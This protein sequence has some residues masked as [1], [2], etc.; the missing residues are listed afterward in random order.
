[1][2][3]TLEHLI[4]GQPLGLTDEEC[5]LKLPDGRSVT[6][7]YI[8]NKLDTVATKLR[9][10][11]Y[12]I[13]VR[14]TG[15]HYFGSTNDLYQRLVNHRGS[16]TRGVHKNRFFRAIDLINPEFELTYKALV[17]DS[18]EIAYEIEELLIS[19]CWGKPE[20]MNVH[21]DVK[22]SLGVGHTEETKE[23]MRI[24]ALGRP[25]MT[26]EVKDRISQSLS[27]RRLNTTHASNVGEA[28]KRRWEDPEFRKAWAERKGIREVMVAGVTYESISCAARAH[29]IGVS[30]A[31]R[32]VKDPKYKDWDFV[33]PRV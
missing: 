23:R 27:N 3:I 24:N 16:L 11:V 28:N 7:V 13:H 6:G 33:V 30:T 1:M 21:R 32:R 17:V 15:Q 10:A 26:Q 4:S 14:F 12:A 31:H 5:V 8:E 2:E 18:R 29:G 22:S 25:P 9:V 19:S 20:L